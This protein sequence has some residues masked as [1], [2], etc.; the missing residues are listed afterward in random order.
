MTGEPVPEETPPAP[1]TVSLSTDNLL[2]ASPAEM[3]ALA[4]TLEDEGHL[5]QAAELCR[6]VLAASG[7]NPEVCFQLAELLY[8]LGDMSA[9]RERYYMA[10]ELDEDYVE[11]RANL[12]CVLAETEQL[13]TG[14]GGI[15]GGLAVP[16]RVPG[17]ALPSGTHAGRPGAARRSGAAL[18]GISGPRPLQSLVGR[19]AAA[20]G[21]EPARTGPVVCRLRRLQR[22]PLCKNFWRI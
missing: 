13:G 19:S 21:M 11:A 3:L 10:I 8:R 7:P 9:A 1:V 18:A 12:G 22:P 4:A 2:S 17:R 15:R 20:T 14:G 6:T 5:E 16:R